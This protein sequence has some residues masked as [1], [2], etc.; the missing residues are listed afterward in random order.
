M[1]AV[2]TVPEV[3]LRAADLVEARGFG[4]AGQVPVYRYEVTPADRL[5]AALAIG[6]A[7]GD[8]GHWGTSLA[9]K[10]ERALQEHLGVED[11]VDWNDVPG[12]TA[13][14]VVAALRAAAGAY[15]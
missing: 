7:A 13:A 15:Q 12:R 8:T 9:A 5:C 10:A 11:V 2:T 1:T 14:E 4:Q 3:L 6:V